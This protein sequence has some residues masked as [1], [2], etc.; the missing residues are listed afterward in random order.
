MGLSH[1][2]SQGATNTPA[3]SLTDGKS[4]VGFRILP[5]RLRRN[6]KVDGLQNKVHGPLFP[7]FDRQCFNQ[8]CHCGS[9]EHR[10][11]SS[12][13]YVAVDLPVCAFAHVFDLKRQARIVVD[14]ARS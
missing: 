7:L 11:T 6:G 1:E 9:D 3:R 2:R 8:L 14:G 10:S 13:T 4:W 12:T 5:F